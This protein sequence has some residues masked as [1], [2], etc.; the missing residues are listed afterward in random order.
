MKISASIDLVWKLAVR[1]ART[2]EF[3]EIEPE[4]FCMAVLTF[5]ELAVKVIEEASDDGVTAKLVAGDVQLVREGLQRC[6]VESTKARRKLRKQL[7]TGDTPQKNGKIHRSASSRALFES[8]AKL[9]D[10]S[11]IDTVTPLHLLTALV[12]APT[13]AIAEAVLGKTPLP[14]P[15]PALLHLDKH[16]KDLLKQ[17]A[18]GKI[19]IRPGFKTASKAVLQ[20][21]QQKDRKSIIL[22]S[23]SDDHMGDF[24]A[25]LACA[26][27]GKDSPD[28]LKCRRLI[29]VSGN[30][31]F[32]S[33]ERLCLS[34]AEQAAELE[35]L[36]QLLTEAA[37]H[38]EVILVVPA[39]QAEPTQPHG[40]QWTNLLR[41]KLAKGMAQF[42]C[43]VS[44]A[45]F[46]EHL[47]RD[48][49]WKRQTQAVWLEMADQRSVP[50]EL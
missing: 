2:G 3:K 14:T 37:E 17:V 31:P 30:C 33:P 5:A 44:S 19:H 23:D 49:V 27:D 7:G 13:P 10:E 25:T 16:G 48:A 8:A 24:A 45:V 43:R 28:A 50:R 21:L 36:R 34:P 32:N 40:G 15:P 22:V 9:A 47:C 39:V 26:I 4:H 18:D 1:E 20:A 41:E 6:G 46:T 38:Q 35:R 11:G 12:Q 29:D 42:I